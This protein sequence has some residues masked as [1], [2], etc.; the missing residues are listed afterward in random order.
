M[1]LRHKKLCTQQAHD[2][3]RLQTNAYPDLQK[4]PTASR[5]ICGR[6]LLVRGHSH[7]AA[8][9]IHLPAEACLRVYVDIRYTRQIRAWSW[10]SWEARL[11]DLTSESQQVRRA[12]VASGPLDERPRPR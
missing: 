11:A 4:L 12:A 7:T 9:H 10:E 3:R 8:H 5:Q 1:A 6:M 2:W